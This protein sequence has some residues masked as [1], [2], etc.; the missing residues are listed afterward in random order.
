MYNDIF[1][2]IAR[3]RKY[4]YGVTNALD[5]KMRTPPLGYEHMI[6]PKAYKTQA[7]QHYNYGYE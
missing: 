1:L 7:E 4:D 2:Q 3:K 6:V 5:R